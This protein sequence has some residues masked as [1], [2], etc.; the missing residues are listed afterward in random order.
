M[1]A[2][3]NKS[4][5]SQFNPDE[6]NFLTKFLPQQQIS[7][8]PEKREICFSFTST[9]PTER[10]MWSDELPEGASSIFD[11]ILSHDAKAWNVERVLQNVCP[12]LKNHSRSDKLGQVKS[13]SFDGEKGYAI[14]RLRSSPE[15]DQLLSDIQHDV[16]GGISF[17]YIPKEYRVITPAVYEEDRFGYRTLKAKAVLEATKIDLLEISS[18]EIPADPTVGFNKSAIPK[19]YLKSVSLQGDPNFA[20]PTEKTKNTKVR[21]M[22]LEQA[23]SELASVQKKHELLNAEFTKT[24]DQV[25][26]LSE[27]LQLKTAEL[28]KAKSELDL[29][30][31]KELVTSRYYSLKSK[32]EQLNSAAKLSTTELEEL[33]GNSPIAEIEGYVKGD[34][35]KL[36]YIEFHL[37]LVEKRSPLLNTDIVTKTEPLITSKENEVTNSPTKALDEETKAKQ[38]LSVA[39][40]QRIVM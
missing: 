22:D 7:V 15:A 32:A 1:M 16:A 25:R 19:V 27:Q 35:D 30:Q 33:F 31:K 23:L 13:V 24:S 18:E 21:N 39:T 11:E 10:W 17:G 29:I 8:D 6:T 12:F 37:G 4:K 40:S 5:T 38:L 14:A 36:K 9:R 34:A 3:A 20:V 2:T 28:D 26:S